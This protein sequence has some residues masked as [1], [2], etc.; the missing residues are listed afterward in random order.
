MR[1]LA[2]VAVTAVVIGLFAASPV[3]SET[4]PAGEVVPI[5]TP[6]PPLLTYSEAPELAELVKRGDLPPVAERLPPDP[7]V[8]Q[9]L[10][11]LGSY[12][13][14][15][16]FIE[17]YY[18]DFGSSTRFMSENLFSLTA[19]TGQHRYPNLA[20][21]L[22]IGDDL[23]TFTITLREGV[24]WSDGHELTTEDIVMPSASRTV[25]RRVGVTPK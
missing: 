7:P 12:G 13:G 18:T 9:P 22:E 4:S 17:M 21:S 16:R 5:I 6:D 11:E 20:K 10:E 23:Q 24:K 1:R 14:T 25:S 8:V 19:P 15:I 3:L 2:T